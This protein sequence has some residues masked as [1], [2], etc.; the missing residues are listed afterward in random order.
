MIDRFAC[1]VSKRRR[2]HTRNTAGGP[3][4]EGRRPISALVGVEQPILWPPAETAGA[5]AL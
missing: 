1:I 4:T 3:T 2:D 5:L